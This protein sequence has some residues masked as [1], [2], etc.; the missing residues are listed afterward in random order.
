MS[1]SKRNT[2]LAGLTAVALIG[3]GTLAALDLLSSPLGGAA[4]TPTAV[5]SVG[6]FAVG[7]AGNAG[8]DARLGLVPAMR[9]LP[10]ALPGDFTGNRIVNLRDYAFFV[11]CLS[12]PDVPYADPSCAPGD[13]DEDGD[14]DMQDVEALYRLFGDG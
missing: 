3:S 12:G 7:T 5:H 6:G 13:I 10:P 2:I 11:N 1:G 4:V 14:V 8:I 9:G